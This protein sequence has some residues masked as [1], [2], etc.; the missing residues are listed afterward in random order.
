MSGVASEVEHAVRGLVRRPGFAATALLT[1]SLGIGANTAIISAAR[2]IVFRPLPYPQ[3]DRLVHVWAYWPGGAGNISFPDGVAI[4]ERSRT[5]EAT[6]T[7][8]SYGTVALTGRTPAE[9]LHTSF[10][11]PSYFEI[12]GGAASMGRVFTS[13]DDAEGSSAAVAVLSHGA[14]IRRFG[15]DAGVVGSVI[16]LNGLAFEVVG[17]M[18]SS[19]ADLGAVEGPIPDVFLPTAA[20]A[21]LMGQPP[22]TDSLRLYWGLGRLKP[23]VGLKAAQED[24]DSIA[25]RM[26]QERPETHRG[27]GLRVQSLSDRIR[28]GFTRP[29]FVLMA[30]S[31]FI[32]LIG[33]ANVTNLLLLRLADRKREMSLRAALGASSLRLFRLVF[34]EA[35]V[36]AAFGGA[37]GT[38]AGL[39]I[40]N[41][42]SAWVFTNV[43]ALLDV[44]M[45]P[46]ALLAALLCSTAAI[47]MIAAVPAHHARRA[48]VA[49]GLSSGARSNLDGGGGMT[50]KVLMAAEVGFALVLL[51]AAG[52]MAR[53]FNALTHTP[54]GFD[55]SRLLTF[56]MDLVG[57]R[58]RD[59]VARVNLAD[60][61]LE[62]A[63][64]IRG[65]EA[66]T[67]WGP[68]MLGNATWVVNVA[69]AGRLNDRPD[70]FTMLF[71][72]SVSPGGLD[73]LGIE[74]V[75]GRDFTAADA[76]DA[77]LVGIV[78]ES[79]AKQLWPGQ[80]AVGR[81]LVRSAPGLP[82]ITV[83]GVARDARHRQRYSLQDVADAGLI[84]GLGPQRDI[85]LPYAQRSNNGVTFAIR[86]AAAG[87]PPVESL[88][89]AVA[90]LDPDL[91][92]SDIRF[93]DDRI[94]DQERVPRALAGL[95][96]GAAL[97]AALLAATGIYGVVSQAVAQRTREIGLRSALGARRGHILRLVV[98]QGLRPLSVGGLAG[99]AASIGLGRWLEA[100]LFG[101]PWTDP[102]TFAFA[103]LS[104]LLVAS[105]AMILPARRALAVDPGVALRAE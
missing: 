51:A 22:R 14:W 67:A 33:V 45:D 50:R 80:D 94:A 88:Q 93:L 73:A 39:A 29:A 38:A 10:V 70:A 44:S 31:A 25:R 92:L 42:M 105:L 32:L 99:L 34:I 16:R 9:D 66:A 12:L 96:L 71:R 60:A 4:A 76:A 13:D 27:Y 103:T 18:P 95:L 77:P 69:P 90:G 68:S 48:D 40:S 59:P 64:A 1:L 52:L 28:G 100:L 85:Y 55:T 89:S 102:S 8:Q 98:R 87:P 58:Y 81:Q 5:L 101:V 63:R 3:D 19:F 15:G 37:L 61:F 36:L 86:L 91:P 49:A 35:C 72:H 7:Y 75:A 83:I 82:P 104:L 2:G 43:S 24:L 56:R 53:S 20:A 84:G 57:P 6:A 65:V 97:L 79:V 46:M 74:R 30:G 62:R 17:I 26:E 41:A 47:L 23:G 11:T 78:S 54:L 21:R